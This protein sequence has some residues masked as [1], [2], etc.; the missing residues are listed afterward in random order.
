VRLA[1][2]LIG[3]RPALGLVADGRAAIV[4]D[5]AAGASDALRKAT[6]IEHV[7][8]AGVWP[9]LEDVAAGLDA[10]APTVALSDVRVLP[11]I[12]FPNKVIAIGLNYWDHCEEQDVEPPERPLVFAKFP[13]AIV[14]PGDPIQWDPALT[15]KVDW[16]AELA[17]VIGKTAR[18]VRKQDAYVHVLGYMAS[19]D[20][21]AR[22]LQFGDKQWV[23]GKSLDSF[24]PLGPWLATRDEVPDPH[25]LRI[26]SRVNGEPMQDSSTARMI[27]DVPT[28]I[29]FLS[30]AFTLLP[31]DVILTGTPDGVG[32][33]RD[34]PVF[35]KD[36]DQVEIE[37]EGL[38]VLSN[39]CHAPATPSS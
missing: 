33:F 3:K 24:C 9:E 11:P 19:N 23:R 37:I 27:F 32:V 4:S 22:D 26:A 31:G 13:S 20:V 39:P 12:R 29:E 18:R 21:S 28:L 14:G 36:G 34:P 16:E 1:N 15:Q 8:A 25:A 30:A 10:K 6:S 17:V 38:G 35:L 5:A 7:L 2:L